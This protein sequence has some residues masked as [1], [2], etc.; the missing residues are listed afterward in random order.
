MRISTGDMTV[1]FALPHA[2]QIAIE[3]MEAAGYEIYPVGGCVRDFLRGLTPFD[4]D[5]TTNARPEEVAR[6]F[7]DYTV[8]ETGIKHGT[9]TVI[10]DSVPLEITTF[11]TD[12]GYSDGRH[13]DRVEF[14]ASLEE[15]LA[16]RDFTVNALAWHRE[17]GVIDRFGGQDDLNANIIRCVGD[18]ETRFTEDALRILRGLRFAATFDF[19]IHPETSVAMLEKREN[20]RHVSRER[21]TEEVVRLVC[22]VSAARII[23]EFLPIFKEILPGLRPDFEKLNTLPPQARLRLAALL[24][25]VAPLAAL[26]LSKKEDAA[27]RAILTSEPPVLLTRFSALSCKARYREYA[28]DVCI[29]H[30]AEN[31]EELCGDGVYLTSQLAI[32]GDDLTALGYTG[33]AVGDTLSKLLL[34][35]MRGEIENTK[36][37]LIRAVED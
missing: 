10:I 34:C 25:D 3:H 32:S 1:R 31:L 9:V 33:K 4:F 26:R 6:V 17:R 15:D 24:G 12:V 37:A 19:T 2:V 35:V 7:S 36:D 16:R 18:A 11:R 30:G 20:L 29:Y 5:L 27:L 8:V 21:I 23:R 13:P 14:S 28:R 22:G